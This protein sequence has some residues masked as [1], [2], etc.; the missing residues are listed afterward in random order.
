MRAIVFTAGLMALVPA[1][2]QADA[3]PLPPSATTLCSAGAPTGDAP[4]KAVSLLP[5]YGSARWTIRTASPEAQAYFDNG[6]QLGHAFA[7][8]AAIAAFEEAARRDPNC[9]MCLWGQAWAGGATINYTVDAATQA[10]M[11]ALMVRATVLAADGPPVERALIAAMTARYKNGGGK[12]PGDVAYAKAMEALAADHPED[13]ELAVLAADAV[14]VRASMTGDMSTMPR[15]VA[16]L[17]RALKRSPDSAAGIHF[18]IHATE[19]SGFAG[20]AEPYADRLEGV[21][22]AASHLVHMPSHTYYWVGRYQDALTSNPSAARID[23]ANAKAEGFEGEDGVFKLFY[24][25]HNVQ[26]GA[27]GALM[28]GDAE[29]GLAIARPFL[30]H[31]R[32]LTADQGWDQMVAGTAYAVEGRYA[33]VDEVLALPEPALPYLKA[34][35]R[36]ARGEALIRKGDLDGARLEAGQVERSRRDLRAFGGTSGQ[37]ADATRVARLV[38]E[39]RIAMLENRPGDAARAFRKAAALEETRFRDITDPPLWWYPVRRSLAA[40]MLSSGDARGAADEARAT[41]AR[42]PKDPIT[43][44]VLAQAERRLGLNEAAAEHEAQARRGWT[45]DLA[46]IGL[47]QS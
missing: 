14:M 43:L 41:L 13:D 38:L 7:H 24:H 6:L 44:S 35:W 19:M 3:P 34:M 2:T 17:E 28:S 4:A 12:G 1:F 40:A 18:Y 25:A 45:G 30:V 46:R 37:A 32:T 5:G 8:K 47:A 23:A 9:A 16:L 11:A 29:G 36:Y 22:P 21:A 26:F 42:R 27:A 39:G 33:P 31:A 20:R 15:A 10:K